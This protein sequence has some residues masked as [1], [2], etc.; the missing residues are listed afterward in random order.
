MKT[1][2]PRMIVVDIGN[3][4]A[5]LGLYHNGR[6]TRIQRIEKIHQNLGT[7]STLFKKLTGLR[8]PERIALATVVPMLKPLWTEAAG[9]VNIQD[10]FWI[11][12]RCD[13]GVKIT[14]PQPATIGTDR[15]ANA[16]GAVARYGAPVIVADFGTALTFD[17]ITR[18]DGYTGGV[19]APG[20]PLMLDYLAERTAQL[21][22]ITLGPIR[23]AIGKSTAEA[24]NLG[25]QW[26]YRGMVREILAELAR[27]P[28]LRQARIVATGGFAARVLRGIQPMPVIDP[29]LTLHGIGIIAERNPSTPGAPHV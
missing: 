16:A 15:L 10:I 2:G 1:S 22:R 27:V 18:R 20:L 3:T 29:T 9:R 4:S 7:V 12:H 23:S 11:D 5:S 19:I 17:L 26:G 8:P 14:Y 21:P 6:V 28:A 13:I 24:I 25:A